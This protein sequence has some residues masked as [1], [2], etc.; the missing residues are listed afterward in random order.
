M[1]RTSAGWEADL[2]R[3]LRR[4]GIVVLAVALLVLAGGWLA[5]KWLESS[6][7]RGLLER[8]LSGAIG[9]PVRLAGEYHFRLLPRIVIAGEG[10]TVGPDAAVMTV[11]E[12]RAVVGLVPLFRGQ[13]RIDAVELTG[14][15][16]DWT[17]LA[18]LGADDAETGAETG[19]GTQAG[20]TGGAGFPAVGELTLRDIRLSIPGTAYEG[21]LG[22]LRIVGLRPGEDAPVDLRAQLTD[23]DGV[24]FDA[25][26]TGSLRIAP[27]TLDVALDM[28]PLT[29]EPDS[30]DPVEV[31]GEVRWEAA[32]AA[33]TADLVHEAPGYRLSARAEV[34]LGEALNGNLEAA[35]EQSEP[36]RTATAKIGFAEHDTYFGLAPVT[37][38]LGDAALAG[39]GCVLTAEAF[40]LHLSLAADE[41]DFDRLSPWMAQDGTGTDALPELP[42]ELGVGITVDRAVMSGASA[43]GVRVVIGAQ[44]DCPGD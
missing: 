31:R 8:Q 41:L 1:P 29:L 13:L 18:E 14:G 34:R 37:L 7:G 10:L 39:S 3:L 38:D 9:S 23:E 30:D 5:D 35:F 40:A 32:A 17:A 4:V 36:A 11:D 33:V 25:A 26:L 6:G 2:L 42:F 44:P 16:V 28:Q 43:E 12:F 20:E 15:R 19:A 27:E 24:V 21:R 22:R